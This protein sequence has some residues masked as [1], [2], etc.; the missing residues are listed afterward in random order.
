MNFDVIIDRL[1]SYITNLNL[2]DFFDFIVSFV[3]IYHGSFTENNLSNLM[4]VMVARI[5][6]EHELS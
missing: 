4:Q 6:T 3:Q 2:P 5:I 1:A